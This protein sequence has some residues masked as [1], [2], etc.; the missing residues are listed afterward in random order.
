MSTDSAANDAEFLIDLAES[1]LTAR[2]V[3]MVAELGI[4]DLFSSVDGAALPVDELARR[5]STDPAV[6]GMVLRLLS[7]H[8]I[9]AEPNDNEFALAPR[10]QA[11]RSDHPLSA[12]GMI[13]HH[14][15]NYHLVDRLDLA[16]RTGEA[17]FTEVHGKPL[18]DLLQADEERAQVFDD[19]MGDLSRLETDAVL[20]NYDFRPYQRIVDVGGGNGTLLASVVSS[21]PVA[22]GVVF[23]LPRLAPAAEQVLAKSLVGDRI[24]FVGGDFFEST[25]PEGDLLVLKS[26]LHDWPDAQVVQIL[27]AC[28]RALR[29]GGR[30]VLFERMLTR[31]PSPSRTKNWDLL[32][33]LILG[34]RERTENDFR[35]LLAEAD[36]ELHSTLA[37]HDTLFA[38]EAVATGTNR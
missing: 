35:R 24:A 16:L 12:R 8:G 33:F 37:M 20:A 18:F 26:I 2:A 36:L 4:A 6:L 21:H 17:V 15:F 5:T 25:P 22:T 14:G 7:A 38:L 23:D 11:L 28:R 30:I 10:G 19:A 34:G 3:Q 31:D 32:L 1:M 13:R 27:R 29:P 9:F